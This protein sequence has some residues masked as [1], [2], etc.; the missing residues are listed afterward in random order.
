[1]IDLDFNFT[2]TVWLWQAEKA[3]WHFVT[4]PQDIAGQIKFTRERRAGFG[5]VRVS[6][7]IGDTNWKTSIFPAK[8]ADS[9][10][11]PLKADVRKKEKINLEDEIEIQIKVLD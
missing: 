10:I 5:S 1:M 7:T 6:V 2:A 9:Y 3:A 8:E 4:L 11:L